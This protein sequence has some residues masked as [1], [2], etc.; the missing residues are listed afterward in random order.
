VVVSAH[1]ALRVTGVTPLVLAPF[2]A[3]CQQAEPANNQASQAPVPQKAAPE[4]DVAA[5]E[6][7]VR[8]RIG[9]G[10]A[11][12]TFVAA[13]R[14]ASEGVPI[15]CGAYEQG[16]RRQRYIVV[17]R[18]DTFV[19]PQMRP[20]QMDRAVAEFCGQGSDNRPP[21]ATPVPENLQ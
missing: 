4:T 9:A 10:G 21:P 14:S 3:A 1:P 18:D 6:R 19:E 7:L 5:A 11:A 15:V 20:G 12:I 16:G 2:L 17:N 8:A 13:S